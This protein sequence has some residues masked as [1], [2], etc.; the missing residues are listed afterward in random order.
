MD[1]KDI[2]Q[3]ELQK[4]FPLFGNIRKLFTINY[5]G[6]PTYDPD[7]GVVE[8]P[9]GTADSY[10]ILASVSSWDKQQ[11]IDEKF[12]AIDKSFLVPVLDLPQPPQMSDRIVIEGT[13]W[14]IKGIKVD[15]ADG[16]YKMWIR[17]WD[18]V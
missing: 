9:V 1:P 10:G 11:P 4:N 6:N 15:P 13:V 3:K 7:T 14:R 16:A 17:P 5:Y 8:A 18:T 2:I 12:L